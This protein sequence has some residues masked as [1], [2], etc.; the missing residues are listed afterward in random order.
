M[1]IRVCVW[2]Y[3]CVC[4]NMSVGLYA[5]K[6]LVQVLFL[7]LHVPTLGDNMSLSL[8]V[9]VCGRVCVLSFV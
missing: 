9:C 4:A 8:S 2:F 5:L 1:C 7:G 6:D 3:V